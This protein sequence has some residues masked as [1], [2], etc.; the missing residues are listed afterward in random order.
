MEKVAPLVSG[1]KGPAKITRIFRVGLGA[2]EL[3]TV[4]VA[5]P[6]GP[7]HEICHQN[8]LVAFNIEGIFKFAPAQFG[9]IAHLPYL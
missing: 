3:G 1:Q 2:R 4:L 5:I 9:K 7:P 8:A 6:M